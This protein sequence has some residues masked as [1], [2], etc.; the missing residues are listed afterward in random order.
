[1]CMQTGLSDLHSDGGK[2]PLEMYQ[3]F[4]YFSLLRLAIVDITNSGK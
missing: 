4:V 3:K 1:M 2:K